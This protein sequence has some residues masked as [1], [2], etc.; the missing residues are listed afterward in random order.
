MFTVA[1]N[2]GGFAVRACERAT[3]APDL[4]YG[5]DFIFRRW[6]RRLSRHSSYR[7]R[8]FQYLTFMWAILNLVRVLLDFVFSSFEI[9]ANSYPFIDL[10][11]IY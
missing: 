1:K 3:R 7:A 6:L 10:I 2:G 9:H 11:P 4:A 5:E 8:Y